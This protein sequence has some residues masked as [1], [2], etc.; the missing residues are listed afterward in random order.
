MTNFQVTNTSKSPVKFTLT[1]QGTKEDHI[2]YPGDLREMP[3]LAG[4]HIDFDKEVD[5]T[6]RQKKALSD[7]FN[8]LTKVVK[9]KQSAVKGLDLPDLFTLLKIKDVHE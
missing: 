3:R 4:G 5:I 2:L 6:F 8:L 1:K 7:K 9:E